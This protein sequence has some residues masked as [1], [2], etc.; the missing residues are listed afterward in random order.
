MKI[1]FILVA[2]FCGCFELCAQT[3]SVYVID[4]VEIQSKMAAEET[5]LFP[6]ANRISIKNDTV[7][8]SSFEYTELFSLNDLKLIRIKS[9]TLSQQ[10]L[11]IGASGG[12]VIGFIAGVFAGSG[13]SPSHNFMSSPWAAGLISGILVG[14][15]SAMVG[16]L[17]GATSPEFDECN[18][19]QTPA[20]V[21]KM[22][23]ENFLKEHN[24]KDLH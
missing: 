8:V 14:G 21:K 23:L 10:G 16:G 17:I 18:I 15:V 12:F 3:D 1:K 22:V 6:G 13:D 9:G 7:A 20:N 19:G 4:D 2:L 24:P 11:I 5:Y